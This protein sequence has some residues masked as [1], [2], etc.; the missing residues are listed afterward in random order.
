MIL[1]CTVGGTR[2]IF[3]ESE[4][5]EVAEAL[6]HAFGEEGDW[7]GSSPRS[8]GTLSAP[9]WIELQARAVQE[10]GG[11]AIPNLLSLGHEG[12]G[13]FLPAQVATLTLPLEGGKPLCCASLPGLRG[14]LEELAARW[15]LPMDDEGLS[16]HLAAGEDRA[17]DDTTIAFARLALAANEAT[18]KD[19]PLWLF[20]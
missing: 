11:D 1:N 16:E 14:E 20:G 17:S 19:C 12:R 9:V 18:R 7:E 6:D 15:K 13:V 3:E 8:F 2:G 4:A 10:L 5:R